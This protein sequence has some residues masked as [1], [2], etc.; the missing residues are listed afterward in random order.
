MCLQCCSNNEET[1]LNLEEGAITGLL[2]ETLLVTLSE[3]HS[4][5]QVVLTGA[6]QQMAEDRRQRFSHKDSVSLVSAFL[7]LV[8]KSTKEIEPKRGLTA[9]RGAQKVF[10]KLLQIQEW[11]KKFW[12]R[13]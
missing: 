6:P 7:W 13:N 12:C 3:A 4:G 10:P 5:K 8:N 2:E 9:E 1:S 11:P